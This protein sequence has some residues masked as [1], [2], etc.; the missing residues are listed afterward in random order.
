MWG[1]IHPLISGHDAV[2]LGLIEGVRICSGLA[3]CR[4][5]RYS[6]DQTSLLLEQQ[7]R[8]LPWRARVR[9]QRPRRLQCRLLG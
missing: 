8:R 5:A 3:A 7:P 1:E 6:S 2:A 4:A 9:S